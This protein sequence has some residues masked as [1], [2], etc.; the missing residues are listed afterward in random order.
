MSAIFV[1]DSNGFRI[2]VTWTCIILCDVPPSVLTRHL[3]SPTCG[4][5]EPFA[6][7]SP[8]CFFCDGVCNLMCSASF[9]GVTVSHAPEST[10]TSI[11]I[12]SSLRLFSSPPPSAPSA[13]NS[14]SMP[15]LPAMPTRWDVRMVAELDSGPR[16]GRQ[17]S[18]PFSSPRQSSTPQPSYMLRPS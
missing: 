14:V 6:S 7:S 8:G 18:T 3:R 1:I 16:P 9:A 17:G 15:Q 5:L 4:I 12:H 13:G 10:A 2:Y 11:S